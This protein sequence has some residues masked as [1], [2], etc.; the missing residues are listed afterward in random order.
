MEGEPVS[1]QESR[2]RLPIEEVEKLIALV[3]ESG[4]G[5]IQVRHGELEV[6]VKA[7]P[8]TVTGPP[9]TQVS[10]HPSST[11]E[12]ESQTEEPD[13]EGLHVVHA[14]LVGT[15][16]RAPAPGEDFYVEVGDK[17]AAGQTLC[18]VEAMKLMNEIPADISGE[19]AEVGPQDTQG[20][21]YGEPLFYIRPGE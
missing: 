12:P 2:D 17:V 21:E 13:R 15:F 1:E 3:Q 19:V 11:A 8:E 4:V 6:T 20:V 18:I 5:E 7:A 9:A 14:P 16:Y 10:S